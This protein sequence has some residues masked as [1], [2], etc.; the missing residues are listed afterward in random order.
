MA[1]LEEILVVFVKPPEKGE[2]VL[3]LDFPL[4]CHNASLEAAVHPTWCFPPV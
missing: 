4:E 2:A 1:G 3:L